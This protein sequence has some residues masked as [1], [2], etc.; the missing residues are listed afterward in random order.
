[1]VNREDAINCLIMAIQ[2]AGDG[3]LIPFD[4]EEINAMYELIKELKT[5]QKE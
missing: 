5:N 2:F 4:E 3:G 1:M